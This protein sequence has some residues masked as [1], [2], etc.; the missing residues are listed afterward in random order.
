MKFML[1][2]N[3]AATEAVSTPMSEWAPE[4]IQA[5]IDF[6]VQVNRELSERGELVEANALT[7]PEQAKIVVSGGATATSRTPRTPSRRRCSTRPGSG[8]C[9]AHRRIR[10]AGWSMS[11]RG[12]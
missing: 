3:Y 10:S 6:Q 12:G 7:G 1:L 8:L 11:R 5:H 9:R 2:Q 4:D